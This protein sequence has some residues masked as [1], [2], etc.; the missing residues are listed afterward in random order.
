METILSVDFWNLFNNK[1]NEFVKNYNFIKNTNSYSISS[2]TNDKYLIEIVYYTHPQFD[3]IELLIEILDI[4]A[5]NIIYE[6]KYL[7]INNADR[8]TITLKEPVKYFMDIF[9]NE[10]IKKI[11]V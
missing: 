4:N 5:N 9:F 8:T 2:I 10:I 6:N 7:L 3:E 1:F 11:N